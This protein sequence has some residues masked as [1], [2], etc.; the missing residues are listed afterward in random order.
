MAYDMSSL[1]SLGAPPS[2]GYGTT[3]EEDCNVDIEY[4]QD[5]M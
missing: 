5:V 1:A 3:A 2:G 4:N